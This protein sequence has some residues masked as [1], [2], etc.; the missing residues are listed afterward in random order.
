MAKNGGN[1]YNRIFKCFSKYYF[2]TDS[3]II[4]FNI[5]NSAI[6]QYTWDFIIHLLNLCNSLSNPKISNISQ[7]ELPFNLLNSVWRSFFYKYFFRNFQE[8]DEKLGEGKWH[9]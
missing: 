4:I 5:F 7:R 3:I 9:K 8:M 6:Y 1:P 2:A